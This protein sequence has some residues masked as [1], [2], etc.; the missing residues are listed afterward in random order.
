MACLQ[1]VQKMASDKNTLEMS[2]RQKLAEFARLGYPRRML[3]TA[4]TTMA[5]TTRC[6]AWFRVRP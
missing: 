2:A 6:T 3:W 1:K 4:C 5:V